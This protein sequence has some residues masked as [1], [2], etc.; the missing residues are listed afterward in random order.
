MTFLFVFSNGKDEIRMY[1][2]LV[3]VNRTT[4]QWDLRIMRE[5]IMKIELYLKHR[6]HELLS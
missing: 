4:S 1:D 2:L 3:W 6:I 5:M